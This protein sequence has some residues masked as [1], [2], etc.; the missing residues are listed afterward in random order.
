[1]EQ[2]QPRYS[3]ER[4]IGIVATTGLLFGIGYGAATHQTWV[5]IS[6]LTACTFGLGYL[7]AMFNGRSRKVKEVAA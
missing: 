1:M 7:F 3:M 4:T 5:G 6:I 2:K